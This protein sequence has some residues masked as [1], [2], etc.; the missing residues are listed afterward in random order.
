MHVVEQ[1][2]SEV[3]GS[4]KVSGTRELSGLVNRFNDSDSAGV[5]RVARAASGLGGFRDQVNGSLGLISRGGIIWLE[6]R[7]TIG[8]P[9]A[10]LHVPSPT[11]LVDG[12]RSQR[13]K[14]ASFGSSSTVKPS[15]SS[16]AVPEVGRMSRSTRCVLRRKR[17]QR[18][19]FTGSSQAI[20]RQV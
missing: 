6:H 7:Q 3:R 10:P 8:P 5:I 1:V 20:G 18:P 2:L 19:A 9:A 12:G 13:V 17:R 16:G 11:R 4:Q 14:K 15:L